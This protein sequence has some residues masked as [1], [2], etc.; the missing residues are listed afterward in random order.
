MDKYAKYPVVLFFCLLSTTLYASEIKPTLEEE[1]ALLV[2]LQGLME[3]LA[4]PAWIK[5]LQEKGDG[6][7][8][9]KHTLVTVGSEAKLNGVPSRC[10]SWDLGLHG[11]KAFLFFPIRIAIE[12]D[13][14]NLPYNVCVK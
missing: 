13:K 1:D 11:R 7:W 10:V 3:R 2:G 8:L 5:L 4:D 14:A 9:D 12:C 6:C